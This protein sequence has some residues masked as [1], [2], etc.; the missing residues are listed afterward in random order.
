MKEQ[1]I[2]VDKRRASKI[3][4]QD[5]YPELAIQL[6]PINNK[7]LTAAQVSISSS[8]MVWWLCSKNISHSYEVSPLAR[9]KQFDR[10]EKELCPVCNGLLALYPDIACQWHY[11]KNLP[12]KV[13][14][15]SVGSNFKAVWICEKNHSHEWKQTIKS[16]IMALKKNV[17]RG[18][19]CPFCLN[20]QATTDNCLSFTHPF[21]E[22]EWDYKKNNA[23][24]L[25]IDQLTFVSR[26]RAS[27]ICSKN[28]AHYWD[29]VIRDRTGNKKRR[30]LDVLIVRIKRCR[31][32][33]V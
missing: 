6:H 19:E 3:S 23:I 10:G 15:V 25:F 8:R 7:G 5:S 29:A 14:T 4:L 13:E 21:L 31:W 16:R 1:G 12:E 27:W 33:I 26:A 28:Q 24:G 18:S 11:E 22:K 2:I 9:C 30:V 20:I 32:I 17:T